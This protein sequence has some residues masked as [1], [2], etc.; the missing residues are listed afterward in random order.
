VLAWPH[1]P[2]FEP[3]RFAARGFPYAPVIGEGFYQHEPETALVQSGAIPQCRRSRVCVKD[4]NPKDG[5][6]DL[7]PQR[8]C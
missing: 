2:Q 5:T 1:G 6:G 4:L 3:D 7:Q 8:Q